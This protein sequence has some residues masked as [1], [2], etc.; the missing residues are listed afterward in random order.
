MSDI[1]IDDLSDGVPPEQMQTVKG[2]LM[3]PTGDVLNAGNGSTLMSPIGEVLTAP[4][5]S[6]LPS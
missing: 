2:G 4:W 6:T 3:S 1:R 5:A